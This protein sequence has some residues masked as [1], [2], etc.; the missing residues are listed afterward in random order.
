MSDI[1]YRHFH[2]PE[3][4]N[5]PALTMAI[6]QVEEP[7]RVGNRIMVVVKAA[8]ALCSP[9]DN[10]CRKIGRDIATQRLNQGDTFVGLAVSE[11]GHFTAQDYLAAALE[12]LT[13]IHFTNPDKFTKDLIESIDQY[14]LVDEYQIAD[15]EETS[16]SSS[17]FKRVVIGIVESKLVSYIRRI[18][19]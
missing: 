18:L 3:V 1:I 11:E 4:P 10:F 13:H 6:E 8:F 2:L 9:E 16:E 12:G 7:I 15:D 14:F 5:A 19:F 17:W